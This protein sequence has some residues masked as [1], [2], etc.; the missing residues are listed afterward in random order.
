V[1]LCGGRRLCLHSRACCKRVEGVGYLRFARHSAVAATALA[2]ATAAGRPAA[3]A[4][5]MPPAFP[6]PPHPALRASLAAALAPEPYGSRVQGALR[7][8][9]RP[10]MRARCPAGVVRLVARVSG[11]N[12]PAEASAAN[13][14]RGHVL[15]TLKTVPPLPVPSPPLHS[16]PLAGP[17]AAAGALPNAGRRN[18]GDAAA[19]T[20]LQLIQR[21]REQ[22]AAA[23]APGRGLGGGGRRVS[24]SAR[25]TA[26]PR[27]PRPACIGP[28]P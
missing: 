27:A 4:P 14:V 13:V 25:R 9:R 18:P 1:F 24:A 15:P 3:A 2:A 21:R 26:L 10:P 20:V 8:L 23:R 7:F 19:L 28:L 11:V 5:H 6:P 12:G 16:P 17:G 22:L